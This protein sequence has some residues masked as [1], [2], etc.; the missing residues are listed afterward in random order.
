M[1]CKNNEFTFK[2]KDGNLQTFQDDM[3]IKTTGFKTRKDGF[4]RNITHFTTTNQEYNW[5][6]QVRRL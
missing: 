5:L 4:K 3:I 6:N 2:S 1:L